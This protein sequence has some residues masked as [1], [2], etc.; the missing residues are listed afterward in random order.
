MTI[1]KILKQPSFYWMFFLILFLYGFSTRLNK[2]LLIIPL[3]LFLFYIIF[4]IKI[5]KIKLSKSFLVYILLLSI[6]T[7]LLFV[8]GIINLDFE[9]RVPESSYIFFA[10]FPL[11]F[12][13]HFEIEK[14]EEPKIFQNLFFS[15]LII[16][17]FLFFLLR[18]GVFEWNRYQHVGNSLAAASILALGL[19]NIK[20]KWI[21]FSTLLIFVLLTGSRQSLFGI[22][23]VGFIYVILNRVKWFLILICFSIIVFV[24]KDYFVGLLSEIA[25]KYDMFTLKRLLVALQEDGG[26]ASVT[27]RIEIYT[28]LL[29]KLTILPNLSFSPNKK[30]LFPHNYF[31]EYSLTSGI[32][33]GATFTLFVFN[34]II[35]GMI[36][37]RNN[38]LLYLSLFYLL[39]FN[40]SSGLAASKYFL[41][42]IILIMRINQKPT[43]Y[44]PKQTLK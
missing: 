25:L 7:I 37:N 29:N 6:F 22:L 5:L 42:F 38:I 2:F 4:N 27:T 23:F 43:L 9:L 35:K 12:I 8:G 21:I 24:N 18:T 16:S 31:L 11:F 26:G 1:L 41:F 32:V 19:K 44:F 33:L 20:L 28:R 14:S 34:N 30:E 15:Y 40:V 17:V 10:M 39:P 36:K 13:F 3:L